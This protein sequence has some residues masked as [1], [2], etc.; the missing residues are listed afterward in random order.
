MAL[1]AI[2]CRRM[3]ASVKI[4]PNLPQWNGLVLTEEMRNGAAS[5]VMPR[6]H[7]GE[8]VGHCRPATTEAPGSPSATSGVEAIHNDWTQEMTSS[9]ALTN[10]EAEIVSLPFLRLSYMSTMAGSDEIALNTVRNIVKKAVQRNRGLGLT[11]KLSYDAQNKQ[12]WQ[13]LEG[14]PKKV[15]PLWEKIRRDARHTIAEVTVTFDRT[16][17]REYPISWAMQLRLVMW[18]LV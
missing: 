14:D 17:R 10:R 6:A 13:I 11:G 7:F 18:D 15:L 3:F 1:R 8:T 12:V 4:F 5:K 2:M 9:D 16:A